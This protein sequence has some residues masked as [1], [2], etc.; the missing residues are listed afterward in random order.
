MVLL[1]KR[2]VII[3]Q[4]KT[5]F[6]YHNLSGLD[7]AEVERSRSI[8]GS[9]IITKKKKKTF[10]KQYLEAFGDPI[11]KILMIALS[12]N[13]I[14]MFRNNGWYESVGIAIAVILSTLVSTLS[15]YGSESAFEK[16][17]QEAKEIN[18]R[19]RR[20]NSLLV[21]PIQDLVVGDIVLLQ[22]G[23]KVLA[24][25]HMISGELSVDQSALNGETKEANK[26]PDKNCFNKTRN[27]MSHSLIFQGSI[28]CEGEGAMLVDYV[29]GRTY[30]GKM[31]VEVQEE[32]IASPLKQRLTKLAKTISRLG[33]TAAIIVAIA[34]LFN[35][36]IIDSGFCRVSIL[37]KLNNFQFV[38]RTL[39]TTLMLAITVIVMA[40]P[41][42]L[43]MMITVV[44]S[45]NMKKML[46]SSK[47]NI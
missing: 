43:P 21:L 39:V 37:E 8:H 12:V 27:L 32:T 38:F 9:N 20:N 42:G 26:Y 33:F 17:Q 23:E 3:V 31:A 2:K 11:I 28:V 34:N 45:S 18:A 30:H 41:E 14:F 1:F 36:F 46:N 25:G 29:G 13:V 35:E 47:K 24:D 40:V 44:L 7:L 22:G 4:D 6:S 19:V 10:F 5:A 16:L 15:E